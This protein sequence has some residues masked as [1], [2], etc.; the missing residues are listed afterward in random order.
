MVSVTVMWNRRDKHTLYSVVC[1]LA[2]GVL[3]NIRIWLCYSSKT[4]G[5]DLYSFNQKSDSFIS[6][7]LLLITT[8]GLGGCPDSIFHWIKRLSITMWS[9]NLYLWTK[10]L[11][12]I[13]TYLYSTQLYW[14]PAYHLA[15]S[16]AECFEV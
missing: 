10:Y 16:K 1:K 4:S 8:H 7:H 3:P 12:S 5:R 11:Q 2:V 6:L 13:I 14:K 9:V 15:F